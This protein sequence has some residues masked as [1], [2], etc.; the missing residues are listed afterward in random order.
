MVEKNSNSNFKKEKAMLNEI[1]NRLPNEEITKI[2]KYLFEIWRK[3]HPIEELEELNKIKNELELDEDKTL[4]NWIKDNYGTRC[5]DFE[6]ECGCCIAW[7][8]Y[9][10]LIQKTDLNLN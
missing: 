5:P 1:I 2:K 4:F 6:K 10:R 7:N 3:H 9:D 8:L